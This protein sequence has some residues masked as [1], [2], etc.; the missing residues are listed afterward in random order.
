[1]NRLKL[2]QPYTAGLG[3]RAAGRTCMAS[4]A[5]DASSGLTVHW[6]VLGLEVLHS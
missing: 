1:M 5:C 2:Y 4:C 3:A 6:V